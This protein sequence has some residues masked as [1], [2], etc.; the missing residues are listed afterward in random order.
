MIGI[1]ALA[2]LLSQ[3]DME[4]A[5]L[6]LLG[7]NWLWVLLAVASVML[8]HGWT[9]LSLEYQLKVLDKRLPTAWMFQVTLMTQA[10]GMVAPGKLG[11]FSILWFFKRKGMPYGAGFAV[12]FY[13]KVIALLSSAW[14]GLFA[15]TAWQGKIGL[16]ALAL[17]LPGLGLVLW[18][19]LG[20]WLPSALLDWLKRSKLRDSMG[21]FLDAWQAHTRAR[22]IAVSML[23]G[24]LK[25]VLMALLPYGLFL[26]YGQDVGLPLVLVAS[27]AV[28]LLTLIPLSPSGVGIRELS[29]TYLF[30]ELAGVPEHISANVMIMSTLAQ[31]VVAGL[32]YFATLNVFEG[33]TP[34]PPITPE[35][36]KAD[37]H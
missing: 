24:I 25:A 20:G 2:Y 32:C 34:E 9:W 35:K 15:W 5:W 12:A 3:V 29:G 33:E 11:D 23:L 28:R 19:S 37:D 22:V 21:A 8:V 1:S 7:A 14:I 10:M 13:Q 26:S 17:M 4:E 30:A 31:F 16:L 27:S 6:A 36:Q 18:M